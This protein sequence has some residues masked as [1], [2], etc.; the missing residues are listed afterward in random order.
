MITELRP[1]PSYLIGGIGAKRIVISTLFAVHVH[2]HV[3]V[4]IEG[5]VG[6]LLPFPQTDLFF[7][8][9]LIHKG[10]CY[11]KKVDRKNEP[12]MIRN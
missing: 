9:T 1:A 2:A 11:L 10:H 8:S 12:Q 5:G 7:P 3:H 6:V 4:W